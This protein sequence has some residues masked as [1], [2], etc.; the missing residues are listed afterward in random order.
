MKKS[1]V[2]TIIIFAFSQSVFATEADIGPVTIERLAAIG[3]K[4]DLHLAGNMEIRIP[5]GFVPPSMNCPDKVHIT[6]KRRND[7]DRAMF[8]LLM[9]AKSQA[10]QVVLRI[11]DDP[12]AE[13]YAGRCS[14]KI[15]DVP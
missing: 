12:A 13:A 1:L 14:L 11:T 9:E 15:V 2:A 4:T 10:K 3:S 8:Y 6:T 5:M 7:P